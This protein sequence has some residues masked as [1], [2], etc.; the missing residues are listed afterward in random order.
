MKEKIKIKTHYKVRAP[1]RPTR[2]HK[3]KKRY[4]RKEKAKILKEIMSEVK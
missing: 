3:N 1:H 4:T 2:V